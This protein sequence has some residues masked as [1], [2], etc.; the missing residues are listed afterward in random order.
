MTQNNNRG[1]M[2]LVPYPLPSAC[3]FSVSCGIVP[4]VYHR[5]SV[6]GLVVVEEDIS[7]PQLPLL[8]T[9]L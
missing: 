3:Q 2:R 8:P 1:W 4:A 5:H 7:C 9:P 6:S